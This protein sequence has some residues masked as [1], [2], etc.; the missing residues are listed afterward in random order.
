MNVL[1]HEGAVPPPGAFANAFVRSIAPSRKSGSTTVLPTP[2]VASAVSHGTVMLVFVASGP[3]L[4]VAQI[5]SSGGESEG[6]K[7][8]CSRLRNRSGAGCSRPPT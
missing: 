1:K 5:A 6:S 4:V 8:S 2:S 7:R 3:E